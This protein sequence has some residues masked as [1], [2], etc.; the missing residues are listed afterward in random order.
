MMGGTFKKI[1][2]KSLTYLPLGVKLSTEKGA[3]DRRLAMMFK[4]YFYIVVKRAGWRLF[5][6][7]AI[8]KEV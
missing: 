2:S 6:C 4:Y 8:K 1:P 5:L 3:T 7:L